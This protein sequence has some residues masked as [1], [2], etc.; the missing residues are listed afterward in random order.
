MKW[1]IAVLIALAVYFGLGWVIKDITFSM[2][3]IN[4]NTTFEEIGN[5]DLIIYSCLAGAYIILC[6]G[7]LM[8]K[9]ND[10]E[11]LFNKFIKVV[12]LPIAAFCISR[13]IIPPSMGSAILFSLLNISGMIIVTILAAYILTEE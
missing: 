2:M 13:Y 5:I 3:D 1:F 6:L 11:F 4:D 7:F 10:S 8:E 12:L 9:V